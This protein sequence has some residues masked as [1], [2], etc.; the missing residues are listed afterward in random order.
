MFF[1]IDLPVSLNFNSLLLQLQFFFFPLLNK[2]SFFAQ[3]CDCV[4]FTSTTFLPW[5]H[6]LRSS[7]RFL[8]CVPLRLS[9][10]LFFISAAFALSA[11]LSFSTVSSAAAS[12]SDVSS[13]AF[14]TSLKSHSIPLALSSSFIFALNFSLSSVYLSLTARLLTLNREA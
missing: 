1:L 8:F 10:A 7:Y 6:I 5:F 13:R 4:T 9:W 11:F 2:I 12:F 14:T 3:I